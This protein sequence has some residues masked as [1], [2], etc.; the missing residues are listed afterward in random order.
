MA[1]CSKCG[2]QLSSGAV[3]CPDCGTKIEKTTGTKIDD[4]LQE[5]REHASEQKDFIISSPGN[6]KKSNKKYTSCKYCGATVSKS[7]SKCPCCRKK[8]KH[9]FWIV[10]AIFV[11]IIALVCAIPKTVNQEIGTSAMT[12]SPEKQIE[13]QGDVSNPTEPANSG[14]KEKA[15]FETAEKTSGMAMGDIAKDGEFY[16]SLLGVRLNNKIQTAIRNYSVDIEDSRE[17]I[18]VFMELY[19]DSKKILTYSKSDISFY[20]DSV[21]AA[22]P[23]TVYLVGLDGFDE[24]QSYKVD[25]GR[26]ALLVAACVVE[27]GWKELTVYSSNISWTVT[28]NDIL[29][30]KF[31]YESVFNIEDNNPITENGSAVY[32]K[33]YDLI[34]DGMEI[35]RHSDLLGEEYYAVFKFTINNTSSEDIDYSLVGYNM[36]GYQDMCLLDGATYTMN[37]TV[38]GYTN[39]YSVDLIKAGLSAKIYVAYPVIENGGKFECVYDVGYI[40]ND[41]ICSVFAEN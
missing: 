31:V 20:I 21:L 8:L 26:K 35:Y 14:T 28:S 24:F 41:P 15:K 12:F 37:D 32:N 3:F 19:N 34:Y 39:V 11:V 18:Y 6:N 23:D 38:N 30:D 10:L 40:G 17:T 25:P 1:Y 22:D 9:P 7:T 5:L 36:R 13:T 29:H 4:D 33:K 2:G 27:K 16:I